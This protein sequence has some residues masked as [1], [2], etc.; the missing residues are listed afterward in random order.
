MFNHLNKKTNLVVSVCLWILALSLRTQTYADLKKLSQ[1]DNLLASKHTN[2]VSALEQRIS[3]FLQTKESQKNIIASRTNS[4]AVLN[5]AD[6][7]Y[8]TKVWDKL[9]KGVLNAYIAATRIPDSLHE[10]ISPG[11]HFEV[12]YSLNPIQSF[13]QNDNYGFDT[14]NNWRQKIGT[15]NGIPDY[16]DEIAWALDSSWSAEVDRFGFQEPIPLKEGTHNSSRYK[17]IA[18]GDDEYGAT[19]PTGKST[20]QKGWSSVIEIGTNFNFNGYTSHPEDAIRVTCAHE[21]FHTIQF[22]MTWNVIESSPLQLDDFPIAWLEGTATAME[23][24]TFPDINDYLQ[25]SSLYFRSPATSFFSDNISNNM[26][27]YTNSLLGLYLYNHTKDNP[28]IYFIYTMLYNHFTAKTSFDQNLQSTSAS[29]GTTW[30]ELLNNFYVSS[31]FSGLNADTDKFLPDAALFDS[32][33]YAQDSA[34]NSTPIQKTISPYSMGIY[35]YQSPS[36]QSDSLFIHLRHVSINDNS[37]EKPWAATA[38]LRKKGSNTTIPISLDST[39]DGNLTVTNWAISD[40]MLV[41]VTSGYPTQAKIFSVTFD[42]CPVTHNENENF[43]IDAIADDRKSKASVTIF[44][45]NIL[46]CDLALTATTLQQNLIDNAKLDGLQPIS[47]IFSLDIPVTWESGTDRKF[48]ISIPNQADTVN[49]GLYLWDNT[50]SKWQLVDAVT[51]SL[52][53]DTL[54]LGVDNVLTGEYAVFQSAVPTSVSMYPNPVSLHQKMISFEGAVINEL[55]IFNVNGALVY[56]LDK[57]SQTLITKWT[58]TNSYNKAVSPGY[59]LAVIK[60]EESATKL[61]KTVHKKLL[62]VP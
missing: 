45:K 31:F 56:K 25:Y 44:S 10:Y 4:N 20:T 49:K 62:V 37:L 1:I 23:D 61:S 58:L 7:F 57:K 59:Y 15:P 29:F 39:G 6:L 11:K 22:A 5:Q 38:I 52:S 17:V 13:L 50:V 30:T 46:R 19:S 41:F 26:F 18:L 16:V 32:L 27:W 36:I 2:S 54:V 51:R 28:D 42:N 21:F 53:K 43:T 47:S 55:Y 48:T 60:Y 3:R 35:T 14:L 34:T 8:L 9:D 33:Y 40:Q 24:L 12:Y